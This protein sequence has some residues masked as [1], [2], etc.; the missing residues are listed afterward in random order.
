M[1]LRPSK[2]QSAGSDGIVGELIIYG[3]KPVCEMLLIVFNWR[4]L[5]LVC[6]RK[7]TGKT[8]VMIEV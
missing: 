1:Y 4:V 5:W 7:G 8:I 6:L 3:G 2:Q